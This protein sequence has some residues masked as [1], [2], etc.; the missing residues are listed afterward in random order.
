LH[1]LTTYGRIT[2]QQVKAKEMELYNMHYGISQPVDTV[3]NC[4]DDLF[5]LA[6]HAASPMSVRQMIDI[7]YVIFAKEPILQQDLRLWNRKP[8]QDRT[9]P[10]MMDHF[11]EAQADLSSLPTAGDIYHQQPAAHQANLATM[12]D[13]VAQRLLEA[14]PAPQNELVEVANSLQRR[15]TDLQTRETAMTTQMQEMM[16][17]MMNNNNNNN[18]N[19]R[20]NRDSRDRG[21]RFHPGRGRGRQGGGGRGN[22]RQQPRLYS[23]SHGACAQDSPA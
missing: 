10:N 8:L 5:E 4:I 6:D 15:E 19:N 3:F 18:N 9:W 12:A 16:M 14:E 11:R 20:N 2:P 7:A 21:G 13:L 22:D 23:W 17:N 1:L